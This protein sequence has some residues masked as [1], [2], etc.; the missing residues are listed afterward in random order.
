[1]KLEKIF[2]PEFSPLFIVLGI[3]S[4]IGTV[5]LLY[6]IITDFSGLLMWYNEYVRGETIAI[7][8]G[9]FSGFMFLYIDIYFLLIIV[10]IIVP[11]KW[12]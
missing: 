6:E 5:S 9:I 3:P 2:P 12:L 7:I 4:M 8:G 10:C 11:K 1:M